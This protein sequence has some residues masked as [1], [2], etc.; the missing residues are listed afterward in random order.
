[1]RHVVM[2]AAAVKMKLRVC[3]SMLAETAS[4]LLCSATVLGVSAGGNVDHKS[5][6]RLRSCTTAKSCFWQVPSAWASFSS[7]LP[8]A[9]AFSRRERPAAHPLANQGQLS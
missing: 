6:V 8:S 1:M 7:Q 4:L 2:G 3:G 9:V 5:V